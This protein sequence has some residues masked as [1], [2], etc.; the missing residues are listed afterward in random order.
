MLFAR[1]SLGARGGCARD[2]MS[3]GFDFAATVAAR[4]EQGWVDEL[5]TAVTLEAYR[6]RI[7]VCSNRLLQLLR[8]QEPFPVARSWSPPRATI[9]AAAPRA[10]TS[11]AARPPAARTGSIS[12]GALDPAVTA[13]VSVGASKTGVAYRRQAAASRPRLLAAELEDVERT[14]ASRHRMSRALRRCGGRR[15]GSPPAGERHAGA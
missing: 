12:V 5:A 6:A 15:C 3:V 2:L 7:S 13:A 11:C 1:R 14:R 4:I 8:L 10:N 9:S